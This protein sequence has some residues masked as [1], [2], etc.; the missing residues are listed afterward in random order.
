MSQP[1]AKQYHAALKSVIK[2]AIL[3]MDA[4]GDRE[5]RFLHVGQFWDRAVGDADLAY[6]YNTATVRIVPTS[7]EIA[8]ADIVADWLAWLGVRD[9]AAV[10]RLVAWAHDEPI[11]RMAEREKVSDRTIHYRIDRSI[12]AI[13]DEFGGLEVDLDEVNEPLTRK[14]PIFTTD[15]PCVIDDE[16]PVSDRHRKVWIDGIGFMLRGRRLNNGQ[17]K[18]TDRMLNAH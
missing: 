14:P 4:T 10:P 2:R 15:R 16:T 18:V 12:A 8:Q 7:R 6:G 17:N 1:T 13:L 9:R 11:W 5:S 3:V